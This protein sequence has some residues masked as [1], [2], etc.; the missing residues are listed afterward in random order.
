MRDTNE[1]KNEMVKHQYIKQ[2]EMYGVNVDKLHELHPMELRR[3]LAIQKM[4]RE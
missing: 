4:K 2:L 3:L 1:L